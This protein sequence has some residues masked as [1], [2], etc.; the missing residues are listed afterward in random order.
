MRWSLTRALMW[1]SCIKSKLCPPADL[2]EDELT[3]YNEAQPLLGDDGTATND[4]EDVGVDVEAGSAGPA[5]TTTG[6]NQV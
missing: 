2:K 4:D 6:A 1:Y 5:A 3:D